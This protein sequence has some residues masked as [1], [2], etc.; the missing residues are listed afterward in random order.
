MGSK[1]GW[2]LALALV[3]VVVAAT[4]FTL[5]EPDVSLPRYSKADGFLD[6]QVPSVPMKEIVGYEPS[7]P[8]NAAD[9]YEKAVQL[10]ILHADV[11]EATGDYK[12]FDAVADAADLWSDP[13]MKACKQIA[14]HVA[15]G[16]KKRSMQYSFLYSPKTLKVRYRHRHADQLYKVSVAVHLLY[17]I[18][19]QR[20]EYPEAEKLL[21]DLFVMGNHML[22]EHT[23]AQV[24]SE[25]AFLLGVVVGRFQELYSKWDQAPRGLLPRIREYEVSINKISENFRQKKTMLWDDI[26]AADSTGK[27]KLLA[28]DVFNVAENDQDRAW[29]VQ[30]IMALGPVKFRVT[31]RGDIKKARDLIAHYLRSKDEV[32]CAA[33]KAADDLTREQFRTMATDFD[34]NE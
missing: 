23:L 4:Y 3:I 1:I 28:G 8:G 31:S 15:A 22:T 32:L 16:A 29:R 34:E 12:K 6:L 25:G 14:E 10:S 7:E 33:A 13:A 18:R 9:D 24:E 26:P 19:L 11:I 17:Q 20:K 30:A 21:K 2:I 5:M 27:P